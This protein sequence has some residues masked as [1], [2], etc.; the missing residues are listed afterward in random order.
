[1]DKALIEQL[2]DRLTV[3]EQR[4]INALLGQQAIRDPICLAF[5]LQ[6]KFI[7]DPARM[8]A[9][10]CTRRAAKTYGA[11]LYLIQTALERKG[12]SSV[13]IGL[14]RD[15]SKRIIWN[16]VLKTILRQLNIV[17]KYNETELT[18]EFPNGSTIYV[19][20]I[21]DSESEKD[22]LL[23]KKYALCIIDEAASYTIDLHDLIYKIL[24][25]ALAD[26][27]GTLVL[28]GTPDDRRSGIFYELTRDIPVQPPQRVERGG[29]AVY[30][31]TT[32]DNPHM[33]RAW[34]ET[35]AELERAD[36]HVKEQ[37]WFRQH[38]LG[39]WVTDDSNKIYRY[40]HDRNGWNGVLP[41]YEWEPWRYVLGLDLGYE[42]STALS[43]LAYHPNDQYVYVLRSEKRKHLTISEV[44]DW[45]RVWEGQYPIGYYI[46]DGANKQA[47]QE[48]VKHHGIPLEA[49]EKT[50]KHNFIRIMNSD[51]VSGKIKVY[52]QGCEALIDEWEKLIWNKKALEKGIWKED[53]SF[54]GDC[55]DSA[56]Y[57]YR[58]C[59]HYA[60]TPA[61]APLSEMERERLEWDRRQA[62]RREEQMY[63]I[64][65]SEHIFEG[66]L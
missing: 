3:D 10:L 62:L 9:L 37:T 28:Q 49:A 51:F 50:D 57:A 34:G 39:E 46:V 30:T 54:H 11:G 43:L 47:V 52:R 45:I 2:W 44:A 66:L 13:Y 16:D 19:L 35:I 18:V 41:N 25:P 24:K 64:E 27:G 14:T 5:P 4:Q 31:W 59:F 56:L 58:Y 7:R 32:W 12:S 8:K 61:S 29:F 53:A 65:G 55:S 63:S 21:N 22:K 60:S 23:G 1:M 38:Y 17:C 33:V 6:E 20:G 26:L 15:Q 40:R 48:I 36:P 42:D